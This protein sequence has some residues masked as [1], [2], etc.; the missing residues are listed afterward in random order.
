MLHAES[1]EIGALQQCRRDDRRIV[2]A[3]IPSAGGGSR[4]LARH[5]LTFCVDQRK[6]V[7][8]H[9]R[10]CRMTASLRAS[11]TFALVAPLRLAKRMPQALNIDH[12]DTRVRSA[13][14][15]SNR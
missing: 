5:P 9:H 7:P 1:A 14:A 2:P 3:E 15:A 4:C 6:L 12:V 11:A 13:L 10:R 8:S